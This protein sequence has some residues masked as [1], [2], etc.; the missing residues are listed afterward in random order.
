MTLS[1]LASIG[2]FISGVAVVLSFIFLALQMRQNTQAVRA[3]A[4]QAHAANLQQILTPII[5]DADVAHLFRTG[6]SDPD[7]L[8]DDER[9]RFLIAFSGIFRFYEAARLQWR[10]GQLDPEH[11]H[12]VEFQLRDLVARSGVQMYWKMRRHWHSPEFRDWVET[13]PR[14]K[15]EHGLYDKPVEIGAVTGA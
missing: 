5:E 2:S 6:I 7:D 10:H 11:W 4:S 9:A 1:D 12:S 8:T 15:A 14:E 13:L 3:A